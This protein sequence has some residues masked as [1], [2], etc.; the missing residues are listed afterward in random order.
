MPKAGRK[1]SWHA[2]FD[3]DFSRADIGQEILA[4]VMGWQTVVTSLEFCECRIPGL[5]RWYLVW[6]F[7]R[8]RF[9]NVSGWDGTAPVA[10]TGW[11]Q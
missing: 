2:P 8:I 10:T 5:Q 11:Y 6:I 7:L 9:E 3:A 4:G 1:R